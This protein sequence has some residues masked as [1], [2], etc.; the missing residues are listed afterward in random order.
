METDRSPY[1]ADW[2][3]MM[4]EYAPSALARRRGLAEVDAELLNGG[5]ES[6]E[7]RHGSPRGALATSAPRLHASAVSGIAQ[8]PQKLPLSTS[9][10]HFGFAGS[11]PSCPQLPRPPARCALHSQSLTESSLSFSV[12]QLSSRACVASRVSLLTTPTRSV[13]ARA[14]M[15]TVARVKACVRPIM[16]A[17]RD[18]DAVLRDCAWWLELTVHIT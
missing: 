6:L 14:T 1:H 4:H 10:L 11:T 15:A 8:A 17:V 18:D 7:L 3:C 9:G 5:A 16:L 12:M 2:P 13:R